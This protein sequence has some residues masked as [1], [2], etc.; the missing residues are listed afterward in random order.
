M[1]TLRVLLVAV[2]SARRY[3]RQLYRGGLQAVGAGLNLQSACILSTGLDDQLTLAV[4]QM[5]L[6][7]PFRALIRFVAAGISVTH[8]YEAGVTT[9]GKV[10]E[11][12]GIR[13]FPA[14]FIFHGDVDHGAVPAV[15]Q[16][17][18]FIR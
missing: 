7:V 17:D 5:P 9:E 14:L 1:S 6:P 8:P 15:S 10:D 18:I 3:H 13:N 16:D 11:V 12:H 2:P 4:E